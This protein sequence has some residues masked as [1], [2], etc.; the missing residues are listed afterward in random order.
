[1]ND[2]LIGG[3]V[4][5]NASNIFN[6]SYVM[7][8]LFAYNERYVCFDVISQTNSSNLTTVFE[9]YNPEAL[10]VD[11]TYNSANDTLIVGGWMESTAGILWTCTMQ[12]TCSP[13][14]A[15]CMYNKV[16]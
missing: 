9:L 3:G 11:F 10:V 4:V 7:T 14:D 12:G 5:Y 8:Y 2:T 13:V 15:S 16:V 1:M 6:A